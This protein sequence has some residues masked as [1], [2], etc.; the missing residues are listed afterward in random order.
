MTTAADLHTLL[1]SALDS[2]NAAECHGALTGLACGGGAGGKIDWQAALPQTDGAAEANEAGA[3]LAALGEETARELNDDSM[4]FSPLLPDD[5]ESIDDRAAALR[6]WCRGFLYG[7]GLGFAPG[8]SP[9]LPDEVREVLG[10]FSEIAR[11]E[12]ETD[13]DSEADEEAYAE[14]VEYVRV[15]VQLIF[16]T[17]HPPAKPSGPVLH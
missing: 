12:L 4:G 2:V 14:I 7:F 8:Q 3:V 6:L 11:Q 5:V 10:D 15:G 9:P 13:A 16:E 17:L 1:N